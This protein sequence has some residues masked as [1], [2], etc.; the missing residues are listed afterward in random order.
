MNQIIEVSTNLRNAVNGAPFVPFTPNGRDII[1]VDRDTFNEKI[2]EEF[3]RKDWQP[4]DSRILSFTNKTVVAYNNF[5]TTKMSGSSDI[6]IGDYVVNN[7]Y[8]QINSGK[9]NTDERLRI[10]GK[11][12]SENY[13]VKG[14]VFSTDRHSQVFMPNSAADKKA[15]LKECR[16]KNN[17]KTV[18]IIEST[19][20]DFRHEFASTIN[21]AQGSTYKVVY[22]DL[23]DISVC[24]NQ[25]QLFRLLYVGFSR[26]SHQLILTG[27][28]V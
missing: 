17:F 9:I 24:K 13:G 23:D 7:R 3:T 14:N 15:L 8:I 6:Q 18:E 25:N 5:I 16:E 4:G 2:L 26:A 22:V 21:K 19:W 1:K 11:R 12:A 20:A 10:T 27:D 28:I